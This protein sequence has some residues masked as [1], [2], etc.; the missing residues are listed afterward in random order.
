MTAQ[1]TAQTDWDRR[2][3]DTANHFA[4]F[5]KDR[6]RQVGCVIIDEDHGLVSQGWNGFARGVNDNIDERHERPL[7]YV[8]TKHAEE[9]AFLNAA[10][11]G[12]RTK[13]ATLYVN[14]YPCANCAGD[15]VQ[16]G[17][18]TVVCPAPI[19]DHPRWGESMK[20][21][22]KILNEGSIAVRYLQDCQ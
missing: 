6:N 18:K 12:A 13:G 16:A 1:V 8:Y 14:R 10:R 22:S 7:K 2:W 4:T 11:M 21:A 9:N 3:M 19:F 17:I 15:I 5:S 20:E